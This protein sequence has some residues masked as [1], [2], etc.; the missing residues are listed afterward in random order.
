V[1]KSAPPET[2]YN[3]A[4]KTQADSSR[5]TTEQATVANRPDIYTPFG[6]QT[7]AMTPQFDPITGKIES[8]WAQNTNLT[9]AAQ[10][11]LDS[12]Q[13]IGQ[14]KSGLAQGL[15]GRLNDQENSPQAQYDPFASV[16]GAT[17]GSDMFHSAGRYDKNASDASFNSWLGYNQPLMDQA[18]SQLDTQLQNQ[19]LKPGDQAYDTAMKNLNT[20]QGQQTQQATYGAIGLG[21]QVGQQQFASDLGAQEQ[22]F[23]QGITGGNFQNMTRQAQVA[24]DMQQKGFTLNQINSILNGTQVGMPNMPG[25]STANSAQPNQALSAAQM[26]GQQNMDAYNANQQQGASTAEGIGS[27][28]AMAAL[29]FF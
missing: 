24:D 1:S 7:W 8:T 21:N 10:A 22:G 14:D 11:A 15:L 16:P 13:A 9:P 25:F 5:E 12:Q 17:T 19:G 4:A 29:A 27:M 3:A 2:D 28:A 18:K 26:T 6:S 23:N 20:Q